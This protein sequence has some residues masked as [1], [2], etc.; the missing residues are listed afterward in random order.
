MHVSCLGDMHGGDRPEVFLFKI[1]A[2][3]AQ[4]M[5]SGVERGRYKIEG[6]DPL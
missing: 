5:G 4:G 6:E 1:K 3:F 2:L